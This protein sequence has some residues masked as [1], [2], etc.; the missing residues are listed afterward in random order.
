MSGMKIPEWIKRKRPD[1][2][3]LSAMKSLLRSHGLHTVCEEAK[4]PNVGECFGKGTATFLVMGDVCTRNCSFCG[5]KHG[6]PVPLDEDEPERVAQVASHLNLKHVVLTSVSRDDLDDGGASHFVNVIK[7]VRSALP[8]S[9]VEVLVPDFNGEKEPLRKVIRAKPDVVNHNVETVP[10]LYSSVRNKAS[11][12]RS[13]ELLGQ[14]G[15]LDSSIVAKS[16]LMVG[17]G[18]T[19]RQVKDVMIDLRTC[20]VSVLTVGQYLRPPGKSLRVKKYYTPEEFEELEEFG[21]RLGF[22]HVASDAFVRSSFHAEESVRKL[23]D[24]NSD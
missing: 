18:E 10:Q 17:L 16:G 9:T 8:E 6:K 14:I 1:K 2:A 13:L 22:G 23:K 15:E 24:S 19:A 11:Y 5:V 4:C 12:S 21:Y 20:G 7:S 3:S